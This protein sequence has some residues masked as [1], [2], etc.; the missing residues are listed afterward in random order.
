MPNHVICS[1]ASCDTFVNFFRSPKAPQAVVP[2]YIYN[3]K[4]HLKPFIYF[5]S[6][7]LTRKY[8]LHDVVKC[9]KHTHPIEVW[10]YSKVNVEILKQHGIQATWVQIQ[11]PESYLAK[12]RSWRTEIL[13]DIGFCGSIG[14][15]R[16]TIL[17]GLKETGLRVLI[18]NTVGGDARD[19]QLAKCKVILNIHYAEDYQLFELAR[20]EPWLAIGVPVISENSLDNDSRCINVDY[21]DLVKTVV[22][23]C[24][25]K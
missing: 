7:Q 13:Y 15:R 2:I 23:V 6:E 25:A 10:D 5:N 8:A 1:V 18:L 4:D 16:Q 17:D 12:L 9:I 20:C 19:Q 14:P 22:K 21:A 11:S 3:L 24:A